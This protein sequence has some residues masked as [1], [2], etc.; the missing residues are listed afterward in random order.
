[1]KRRGAL[2]LLALLA[3]T[4]LA[5]P[6][7]EGDDGGSGEGFVRF[8][9]GGE[10]VSYGQGSAHDWG[11]GP[12]QPAEGTTIQA[13][14]EDVESRADNSVRIAF[15]GFSPGAWTVDADHDTSAAGLV[16]GGT[17]PQIDVYHQGTFYRCY[18]GL[19]AGFGGGCT[20]TVSEFGDRVKGT[21]SGTLLRFDD[22]AR[23]VEEGDNTVAIDGGEFDV[24]N[25]T[26]ATPAGTGAGGKSVSEQLC[27]KYQECI[28]ATFRSTYGDLA[29]CASKAAETHASM[30]SRCTDAE[31]V[32]Q[33]ME[34]AQ[35]CWSQLACEP[36]VQILEGFGT[37]QITGACAPQVQAFK[38]LSQSHCDP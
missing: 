1:M 25:L 31:S 4:V 2:A 15:V 18:R 23:L 10:E 30:R 29:G 9:I 13:A 16:G 22:H 19:P 17:H 8:T 7:C 21:F 37:G 35:S 36:F 20:I 28:P 12:D 38:D 34:V 5:T 24:E 33:T 32:I 11:P 3:L 14:P 27:D 6:A 26:S